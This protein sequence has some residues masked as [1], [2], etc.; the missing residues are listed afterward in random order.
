MNLFFHYYINKI[1]RKAA[2]RWKVIKMK[3]KYKTTDKEIKDLVSKIEEK[4]KKMEGY[5]VVYVDAEKN[6][7]LYVK[8]ILK[9]S[10]AQ[11]EIKATNL[12]SDYVKNYAAK[13]IDKDLLTIITGIKNND[14]DFCDFSEAYAIDDVD[15]DVVD[16]NII[17]YNN[18]EDI[19]K[20]NKE[21][22]KAEAIKIK[23]ENAIKEIE[24][25]Q[26][27]ILNTSATYYD[28]TNDDITLRTIYAVQRTQYS[29]LKFYKIIN[30]TV[31]LLKYI[32]IDDVKA[33]GYKEDTITITADKIEEAHKELTEYLKI[34]E[35]ALQAQYD[36]IDNL[37]EQI[38]QSEKY[39]KEAEEERQSLLNK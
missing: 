2:K 9:N 5:E 6:I 22:E 20:N 21:I 13:I 3:T 8:K 30:S 10:T 11:Y 16:C 24:T 31:S 34:M 1:K 27:V 33:A 12:K 36:I 18:R 23:I 38:R 14:P 28:A 39:L 17:I 37:Q 19:K 35:R 29:K 25:S 7:E 15:N 4:I 32:D 26:N